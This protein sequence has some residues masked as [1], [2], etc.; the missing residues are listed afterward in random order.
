MKKR[1]IMMPA[2]VFL[3]LVT[4]FAG[5]PRAGTC[6]PMAVTAKHKCPTCGMR[7]A[8]YENWYT[9]IV[10][11]S[12]VNDAFCGVKCLMAFY[13]EPSRYA[14]KGEREHIQGLFAKDYYSQHWHDMKGMV[15]VLGSDVL[16]PMGKELIPFSNPAH[17]ETFMQDHNG[18]RILRFDEITPDLIIHLRHKHK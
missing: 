12:G 18:S 16:G 15:Y 6:A 5:Q 17:A 1:R 2:V 8:P 11:D 4:V 14:A 10:Y 7:V 13:F 9:Q 3:L